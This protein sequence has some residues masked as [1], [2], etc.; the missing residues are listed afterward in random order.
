[1]RQKE[2]ATCPRCGHLLSECVDPDREWYPQRHVDYAEM[3]L[4][5]A[6]WKYEQ[7]HKDRPYHDG[8]F[9]TWGKEQTEVTPFRYDAGVRVWVAPKD[10]DPS[11]DFLTNPRAMPSSLRKVVDDGRPVSDLPLQG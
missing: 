11:D 10:H 5:Y 6:E 3:A 7:L 1:M 8:S 4:S 9:Q 2:A